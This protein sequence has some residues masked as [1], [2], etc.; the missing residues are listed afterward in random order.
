MSCRFKTTISVN[1]Y[2]REYLGNPNVKAIHS[3]NGSMY[4][5]FV[6]RNNKL[7][8]TRLPCGAGIRYLNSDDL[9]EILQAVVRPQ[10]S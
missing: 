4:I 8:Y 9:D 10:Q 7:S 6:D 5:V 1:K 2:I 3:T